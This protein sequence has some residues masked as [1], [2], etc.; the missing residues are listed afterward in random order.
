MY[1]ASVMLAATG[2]CQAPFNRTG[3]V[4]LSLQNNNEVVE[5]V[6]NPSSNVPE[7]SATYP[8]PNI[9]LDAIGYRKTDNLLYGIN[10]SDNHLFKVGTDG[11]SQDMGAPPL[12]NS[13]RY[14]AGDVSPDGKELVSIGSN[15]TQNDVHLAKTNLEN[16]SFS[17]V[18]IPL[19]GI[20]FLADVAF[21]PYTGL[22]YGYDKANR[23]VVKVNTATG[24]VTVLHQLGTEYDISGLYFDAFG[25]LHGYGRAVYGIV[26]GFFDIDKDTGVETLRATGPASVLTDAA[27]CPFSV[28]I[29]AGF[30][31]NQTLPC[32][33]VLM[34]YT[35]ANGSGEPW[36][37]V[38]FVYDLPPG[39]YLSN[40]YANPFGI[41]VDTTGTPGTLRLENLNLPP[42]LKSLSFKIKVGD[43]PKGIYKSQPYLEN[44]SQLYGLIS[45]ADNPVT[46]GFEDSTTLKVNRFDEDSL[47]FDWLVCHGESL[48]FDASEYGNSFTWN[49]GSTT[50]Q[51]QVTQGG[52]YTLDIGSSC[53]QLVVKHEV[54]STSCPFT[55]A[56]FQLF[57]P[58]SLF[59]C[60]DAIFRF[61]LKNDSG[62]KRE[63]LF[64]TETL[65][66]GFTFEGIAQNPCGG[67]VKDGLPPNIFTLENMTLAVGADTLDI[68]VH[69][70]DV[71]PS[72][73][74]FKAVLGGLPQLMGPIRYSDD[75]ATLFAD[76]ST[77]V[78]LGTLD[79]TLLLDTVICL[80]E[81]LVLDASNFGNLFLWEDGSTGPK[82]M[83]EKPGLYHVTLFDGCEP[84]EIYWEVAA[85]NSITV[86]SMAAV[87]IHQGEEIVLTPLI[88]N[89]ED[90]LFI[91][92]TDPIGN[93]LSCLDCPKP[94]AMPLQSTSYT[95]RVSNTVCSDSAMI[96]LLVD[97]SRRIYAPTAFSPNGDGINDYFYLQSPDFGVLHSL[98]INGR[99]GNQVFYSESSFL[100][101]ATSGWDGQVK[102]MDSLPGTYLW[103]AMIEFVDGEKAIF[104]GEVN[105]IR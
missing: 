17:T 13:L 23:N 90:S 24:A 54:T 36:Q 22:L 103:Q 50:S 16:G 51:Y 72:H 20:S 4:F 87:N 76:S 58:D 73:Y 46:P 68:L 69:V 70:G 49:D 2:H 42:G 77:L 75:P 15:G 78:I 60:N 26:D 35:I 92:W 105:V 7:F 85:A 10:L 18:F 88:Q 52:I 65:P 39:F 61:I 99:W 91:S 53:E 89:Q 32:T 67:N 37:G 34:N 28:E 84:V 47:F 38:N 29:K 41:P 96:E 56:L 40:V 83:V 11:I 62:E 98:Q 27:S 82:F 86:D 97:D 9:V 19:I 33:E 45:I 12:N 44:L 64:L 100:N 74:R 59:A 95:I 93:T 1:L 3:Q 30:E 104:S 31:P 102:G 94:V 14:L 101:E 79:D 8:L 55:I 81:D 71:P 43:I 57:E 21:D 66:D 80:K 6:V 5:M 48:T 63:N 25:Q